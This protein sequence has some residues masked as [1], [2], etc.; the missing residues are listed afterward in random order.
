MSILVGKN[1][2]VWFR[3]SP[4][5]RALSCTQMIEYGLIGR[6][7]TLE[8]E[9]KNIWIGGFYTVEDGVSNRS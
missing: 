8:K 6:R 9:V 5:A 2:R 3:A 7:V 1:S 4:V